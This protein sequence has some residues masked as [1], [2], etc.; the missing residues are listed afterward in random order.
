MSLS[1]RLTHSEDL[2]P[3]CTC[4]KC[5]S[6]HASDL[7][8]LVESS[9]EP[10][11]KRDVHPAGRSTV[12]DDRNI[13]KGRTL[14]PFSERGIGQ[15]AGQIPSDRK[16]FAIFNHPFGVEGKRVGPVPDSVVNGITNT[17]ATGK[18]WKRDAVTRT[19][20]LMQKCDVSHQRLSAK[21][22][23][24][25]EGASSGSRQ[26][27]VPA[28]LAVDRI[29]RS[30]LQILDRVRDRHSARPVRVFELVMVSLHS[31]KH[32]AICL[33]Q[34]DQSSA[35]ALHL[36]PQK[37]CMNIHIFEGPGER[38]FSQSL[39]RNQQSGCATMSIGTQQEQLT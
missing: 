19:I 17:D 27:S 10:R 22:L 1:A 36:R 20:V 4:N 9:K 37:V 16:A 25:N 3:S 8:C 13:G 7:R 30:R 28:R 12:N 31:H 14:A 21:T 5:A 35:I 24:A 26:T 39:D 18:V 2:V 32:P 15:N 38:E 34:T 29:D 6:R 11:I 33:Q 23:W